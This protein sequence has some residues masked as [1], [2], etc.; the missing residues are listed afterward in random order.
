[1]AFRNCRKKAPRNLKG[2]EG[3][4]CFPRGPHRLTLERIQEANHEGEAITY[5]VKNH[6]PETLS[7]LLNL[8]NNKV[9]K[10]YGA[11]CYFTQRK[12][13]LFAAD[14]PE[15]PFLA[16]IRYLLQ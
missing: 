11:T 16:A 12:P 9:I 7:I 8:A 1:M 10:I 2:H 13:K 3:E 6:C 5:T 14:I 15:L 4:R